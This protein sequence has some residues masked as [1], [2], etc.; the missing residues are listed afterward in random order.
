MATGFRTLDIHGLTIRCEAD[1]PALA[2][3]MIRPLKYFVSEV[4]SS[5]VTVI[6]TEEDPPYDRLPRIEAQFSTPRNVVYRNDSLKVVDYFGRG[7]IVQESG[8][9]TYRIYT[10]DRNLL[11]E[12]F[13]LLTLSLLGEHCD[14]KGLLRVH[15]LAISCNERALLLLIPS[16][17]GKST[18]AFRLLEESPIKLISDDDPII[19]PN[20]DILSFPRAL[21]TL[22]SHRIDRVPSEHVY[23]V[24]RMEFGL[25]YF[26]DCDYWG[27]KIETGPL[28]RSVLFVTRRV[29]N[30]TPAIAKVSKRA[31]LAALMRDAVFGVGL[32]QGVEFMFNH[33]TWEAVAK[34]TTVLKRTLRALKLARA[35]ATYEFTLSGDVGRNCTVFQEFLRTLD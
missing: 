1:S 18:M 7:V 25:K 27:D 31:A 6:A 3:A 20:G 12:A 2:D 23:S 13:Y 19:A 24:D 30:G 28:K 22:D 32:Y 8:S 16:G 11:C 15:A 5:G 33:S 34:G 4:E 14:R 26:V 17:G 21:G 9:S 29:L 10:R 35:S